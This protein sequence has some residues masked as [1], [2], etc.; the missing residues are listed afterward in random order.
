MVMGVYID[1]FP[2]SG[3]KKGE[4]PQVFW[5]RN[6][7]LDDEWREYYIARSFFQTELPDVREK[8]MAERYQYSVDEAEV[9]GA[10]HIISGVKQW[11]IKKEIYEDTVDVFFEDGYFK[12]A[13]GYHELLTM[14]YGDYMKLPPVEE[15]V[16][17][18]FDAYLKE[19]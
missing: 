7:Q 19:G 14:R 17:H 1:I 4:N 3:Y 10:R 11:C 16:I 8:I 13:A 12:A 2:L 18:G 6:V 5:D 15:R 9:V